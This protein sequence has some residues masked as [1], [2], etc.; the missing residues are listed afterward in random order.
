MESLTIGLT[1]LKTGDLVN[2]A[3]VGTYR[4]SSDNPDKN[5][6]VVGSS[7]VDKA[8]KVENI[9]ITDGGS[10]NDDANYVLSA[11][12]LTGTDGRI[13]QKPITY[14][15]AQKVYDGTNDLRPVIDGEAYGKIKTNK[16][17][18]ADGLGLINNEVFTYN[19]AN[20]TSKH[21]NGPDDD[22]STIGLPLSPDV[23]TLELIGI[24]PKNSLLNS[25]AVL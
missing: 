25:L 5:V 16:V 6:E 20:S 18:T 11:N 7:V 1:G 23:P 3:A 15:P 21:V 12:I 13:N 4:D 10:N 19:A 24:S 22:A 17:R 8:F 14:L 9:S 2:V